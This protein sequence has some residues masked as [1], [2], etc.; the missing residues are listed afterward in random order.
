MDN[1]KKQS[2]RANKFH[3]YRQPG[4]R[5]YSVRVMVEGKRRRF[6]TGQTSLKGAHSKAAAIMADIKSRGFET[7]IRLHSL[8]RAEIPSDPT[9]DEFVGLYRTIIA[10]ADSPASR[11][12]SERYIRSLE[13]V[14]Q[15]AGVKR[16][17][18]LDAAAVERFKDSYIQTALP[19]KESGTK[20][21]K[22]PLKQRDAASV[23]T[24]LNGILR[25]AAAMFS[26]SLLSAYQLRGLELVSPFKG[27]KLRRI[28]IKAYSPLP[29]DLLDRIWLS[30]ALLR[31]GDP[32]ADEPASEGGKYSKN[33]IDFRV[34]HPDVFA[35]FLLELGLGLRRNEA[36]KAEWSW[37]IEGADERRF[38]EVRETAAFTPKSKQSRVIPIDPAVWQALNDVKSDTRFIVPG[39]EQKPKRAADGTKSAVYRCDRAHRILVTWLRKAGVSDTKPC[40]SLRK[41]FGSYVATSFS[42]F[43]AQKLL[44]HSTPAVTSAYY[45][46]L[47]DLPELQNSRMGRTESQA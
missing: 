4:S 44:G 45:A 11:I 39:P 3:I 40:H 9:V 37:V 18:R 20:K 42:L 38:L 13:R 7:A 34:P 24:T 25:N 21:K 28:A 19:T 2:S 14:C 41:E 1:P 6:S 36:D 33:A 35:I 31:D 5:F 22:K 47:T 10:T 29:R 15:S 12:S 26:Q 27:A 30:A 8:R 23:R 17:R 43:H 32:Q 46:S 16:I